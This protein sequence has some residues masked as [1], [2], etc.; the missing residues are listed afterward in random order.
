[1][2]KPD[3]VIEYDDDGKVGGG[4]I[5]EHEWSER[6]TLNGIKS[7]KCIN[8]GAEERFLFYLQKCTPREF[9]L[10]VGKIT[11]III[12]KSSVDKGNVCYIIIMYKYA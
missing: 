6:V 7:R 10:S 8:C 1:M 11:L 5:H 4:S 12:D 2:P 3:T 9:L